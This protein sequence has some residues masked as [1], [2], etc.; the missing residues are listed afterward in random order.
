MRS[1]VISLLLLAAAPPAAAQNTQ[2]SPPAPVQPGDVEFL[3]RFDYFVGMDHLFTED[4]RFV[5]DAHFG[6]EL[7]MVD[8]GYGRATFRAVYQTILGS[9]FR[10]FDPNQGNYTLEALGSA[11]LG[12]VEL[13]GIL[14]H[15]SRHVSDRAKR[16]AVDWNMLGAQLAYAGGDGRTY[17]QSRARLFKVIAHSFVDYT[18]RADVDYALR[19]RLAPR[20]SA[21]GG[22]ALNLTG[23]DE[24]IAGRGLQKGGRLEGGIRL[25]GVEGA[26]ELFVALE[27]RIDAFPTERRA[28]TWAL[29]GFRLVRY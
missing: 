12:K 19:Y 21:I 18:W 22:T 27:R 1:F 13:G 15:T 8:Y 23:T 20:V 29:G 11:R 2:S 17:V 26:L 24:E 4:P 9:Q 25:D 10:A 5:W 28:G 7:D 6:G 3:S 16:F 14:H